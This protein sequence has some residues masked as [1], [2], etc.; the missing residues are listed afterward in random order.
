MHATFCVW[1][2]HRFEMLKMGPKN[3]SGKREEN[4]KS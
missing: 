2:R 4:I 3:K 1:F